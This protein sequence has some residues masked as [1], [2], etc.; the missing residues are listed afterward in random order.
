M[1]ENEERIEAVKVNAGMNNIHVDANSREGK[2]L[3][4]VVEKESTLDKKD[5]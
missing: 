5:T 1:K 4:E 3:I 2:M